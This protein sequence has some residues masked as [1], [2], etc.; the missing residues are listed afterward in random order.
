VSS[1]RLDRLALSLA[2][3]D[4]QFQLPEL[5]GMALSLC[6]TPRAEGVKRC[7]RA[8]AFVDAAILMLPVDYCLTG[9]RYEK[10]G[11]YAIAADMRGPLMVGSSHCRTL[12]LAILETACRAWALELFDTGGTDD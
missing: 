6:R 10:G 5:F 11:W 2:S 4:G 7:V 9:T 12:A 1:G 8:R 3:H